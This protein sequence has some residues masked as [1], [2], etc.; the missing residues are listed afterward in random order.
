MKSVR[1]PNTLT[2]LAE[3]LAFAEKESEKLEQM[4]KDYKYF[5]WKELR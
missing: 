3:R 2:S 1:L 4:R 5:S